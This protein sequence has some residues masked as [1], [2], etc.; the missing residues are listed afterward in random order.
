MSL[1]RPFVK[2]L[3]VKIHWHVHTSEAFWVAKVRMVTVFFRGENEIL[4]GG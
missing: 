2:Y 4:I 3:C 1:D